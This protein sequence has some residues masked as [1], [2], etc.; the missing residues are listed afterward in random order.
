M[1]KIKGWFIALYVLI[2]P[3]FA[4]AL[5]QTELMYRD[6]TLLTSPE[7]A[8]RGEFTAEPNLSAQFIYSRLND[9]GYLPEFQPF[10]FKVGWAG[11]QQGHNVFAKLTCQQIVCQKALIITAHY[12]HL[13]DSGSS[14]YPG[15]NDNASGVVALLY[16]AERLKPLSVN[17]DVI[18]VATDAEE[19]GL[20]GAH[21]FAKSKHTDNAELNI[22]L[23]MLAVRPDKPLYLFA[24]Q[25]AALNKLIPTHT[26]VQFKYTES[27]KRLARWTNETHTDWLRASDHYAFYKQGL[28]FLYVGMGSDPHHH[29]RKD[30]LEKI[31][32]TAFTQAVYSVSALVLEIVTTP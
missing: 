2:H 26:P 11:S 28:T 31:D 18:F 27:T 14:Y 25:G 29:T 13:G 1:L 16:L 19:K 22:N 5:E 30:T 10:D 8:G 9:M 6:L 17:R 12:D 32:Y 23:D 15:A 7:F 3:A 20:H 24:S 21:A 4:I